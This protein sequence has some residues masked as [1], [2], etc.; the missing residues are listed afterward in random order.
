MSDR[1]HRVSPWWFLLTG[2]PYGVV[3]SFSGVVMPYLMKRAG[4][5]M[6]DIGLFVSLSL[7]PPM[8]QF[9]YAPVVDLGIRRKWWL[10]I[11][12]IVGGACLAAACVMPLPA[13]TSAFLVLVFFA[14]AISGLVGTC[15]G[16]LLA[17]SIPDERRGQASAALNIGNLS[18]G[19]LSAAVAIFLT[20]HDAPPIVIGVVLFAMM[21]LPSLAVIGIVEPPRPKLTAQEAFGATLRDVG[22]V[23][24]S[25]QGLTGIALCLSPVGTAALSNYF[26]GMGDDFHVDGDGVAL[27]SGLF[28]AVL[29]AAGA[30]IGG[31]ICDHPKANRR[32]MYLLSG[33]LTAIVG[34]AMV[35]FPQVPSTYYVFVSL[36]TLVTGFCYAAF[37]ASVLET[38]GEGGTAAGTQ[39][40]LFVAAGNAAINWVGLVDTRFNESHGVAGV[41]TSDAAL[42]LIGVAVL[43]VV[44]WRLGAF[45]KRPSSS[46]VEQRA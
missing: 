39:Y 41:V 27:F 32:V 37:T 11:V 24:F 46:A 7:I 20:A 31:F 23:L 4:K 35:L 10:M 29:T 3:G 42:N 8:L 36:Y 43:A 18:G 28:G 22:A 1:P 15:N 25:K 17:T 45:V 6:G 14:Q 16:G 21:V 12:A 2:M 5:D 33:V 26:S 9:L 44:F 38:I 19:A 40:A 30:L 13:Q 34:L